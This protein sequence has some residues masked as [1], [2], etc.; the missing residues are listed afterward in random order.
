MDA[1]KSKDVAFSGQKAET[2]DKGPWR[3]KKVDAS[4]ELLSFYEGIFYI[5]LSLLQFAKR[6]NH[7]KVVGSVVS[8][9]CELLSTEVT[10]SQS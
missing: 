9:Y 1:L 8:R 6:L 3:S 5:M 2:S 4:K 7:C 10:P